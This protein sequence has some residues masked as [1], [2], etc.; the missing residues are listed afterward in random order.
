MLLSGF[1]KLRLQAAFFSTPCFAYMPT[2]SDNVHKAEQ[3]DSE[4]EKSWR[5]R[6]PPEALGK[7][8]ILSQLY[9]RKFFSD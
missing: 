8:M 9:R 3:N 4:K 1:S 6:S 5:D 7:S 2:Q